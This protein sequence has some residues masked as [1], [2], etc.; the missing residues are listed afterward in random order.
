MQSE[1]RSSGS[2]ERAGPNIR[3]ETVSRSLH[4]VVAASETV[5]ARAIAARIFL[6]G[7]QPLT[8]T[9]SRPLSCSNKIIQALSFINEGVSCLHAG[10]LM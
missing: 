9:S 6:F 2:K 8:N 5:V 7:F 3:P 1:V 4:S 10:L